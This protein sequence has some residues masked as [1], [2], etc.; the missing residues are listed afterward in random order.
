M[1]TI[2]KKSLNHRTVVNSLRFILQGCKFQD[3]FHLVLPKIYITVSLGIYNVTFQFQIILHAFLLSLQMSR[4]HSCLR[5]NHNIKSELLSEWKGSLPDPPHS[6]CPKKKCV[7]HGPL[8]KNQ[9]DVFQQEL[10]SEGKM[11][12]LRRKSTFPCI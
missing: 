6:P 9:H 3:V 7:H 11:I 2:L 8:K 12:N 4:S 1:N 10:I 5:I